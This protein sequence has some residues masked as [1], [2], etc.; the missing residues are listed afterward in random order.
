[1]LDCPAS[2][3]EV[4]SHT[5]DTMHLQK[6]MPHSLSTHTHTH[7]LH[8]SPRQPYRT[9]RATTHEDNMHQTFF[10]FL[11]C[12]KLTQTFHTGAHCP[13]TFQTFHRDTLESHIVTTHR[14]LHPRRFNSCVSTTRA[15][16]ITHK[17]AYVM[18]THHQMPVTNTSCTLPTNILHILCTQQR[19]KIPRLP[20]PGHIHRHVGSCVGT[21]L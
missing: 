8:I 14:Y 21:R 17:R 9:Q 7:T 5:T 1:M 11:T 18:C 20:N 10:F 13:L 16:H 12:I 3:H 4:P 6:H 2:R 15:A 19:L